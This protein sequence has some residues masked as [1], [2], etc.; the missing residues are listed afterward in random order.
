MLKIDKFMLGGICIL[1]FFGG[2]LTGSAIAAPSQAFFAQA[3]HE[4][5]QIK[6]R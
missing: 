4:I 5:V 1:L 6:A 2:V 3:N